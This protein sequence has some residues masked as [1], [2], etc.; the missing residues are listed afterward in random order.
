MR[1]WGRIGGVVI[2]LGSMG[3]SYWLGHGVWDA[4]TGSDAHTQEVII[5]FRLSFIIYFAGGFSYKNYFLPSQPRSRS[6]WTYNISCEGN[7][8][9]LQNCRYDRAAQIFYSGCNSNGSL[10]VM[11]VTTESRSSLLTGK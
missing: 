1:S 9:S 8:L 11:C 2:L 7:E 5:W 6:P 4:H 10:G 3:W